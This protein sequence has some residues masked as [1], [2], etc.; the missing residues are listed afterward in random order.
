MA[1]EKYPS[2]RIAN[3]TTVTTTTTTTDY[4]YP[5]PRTPTHTPSAR[6]P[7]SQSHYRRGHGHGTNGSI[8]SNGSGSSAG[9]TIS[10]NGMTTSNAV[11]ACY[12]PVYTVSGHESWISRR[13][14]DYLKQLANKAG[15]DPSQQ[16][17]SDCRIARSGDGN[18]TCIKIKALPRSYKL[19]ELVGEG[20]A[21][22][23]FELKLPDG[24]YF[25]HED[26]LLMRV[27][28]APVRPDFP[29]FDHVEQQWHYHTRIKPILGHY[30]LHS[31]LAVIRGSGIVDA[32]NDYLRRHDQ[33]RKQKFRGTFVD[34][35]DW[36]F[37][38][39]DMR[40]EDDEALLVE[41][42]PKWL[43]QSP[44]APSSAIR[45]RQCAKELRD[46]VSDPD[47]RKPVPTK[48]KP[49]PLTLGRDEYN[50]VRIESAYRLL[51]ELDEPSSTSVDEGSGTS[52]NDI[53]QQQKQHRL[54]AT[55]G[56]LRDEPALKILREAQERYDKVGPLR[57]DESDADFSLAMTLRDCT[58]LAQI[59]MVPTP[60]SSNYTSTASNDHHHGATSAPA[61]EPIPPLKT[62]FVDFDMKSSKHRMSNW[63]NTER[64]LIE[65]GFYTAHRI[66]CRGVIYRPPTMC[67]LELQEQQQERGGTSREQGSTPVQE[68]LICI[69][70]KDEGDDAE[71]SQPYKAGDGWSKVYTVRTDAAKLQ[72]CLEGQLAKPFGP[73]GQ[74]S[75]GR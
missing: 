67:V 51:P 11:A 30:V 13:D 36:A 28:K 5:N 68:E 55:L 69:I 29:K 43:S 61:R 22:A 15:A 25:R 31:E 64:T 1:W 32:M 34:Q 21:N 3:T 66:S 53:S 45:C 26:G 23:V 16:H 35:S 41:F 14:M 63:R 39:E 38:L 27:A 57:A 44:S 73:S 71:A 70:D 74:Q 24:E 49:C 2:S 56:L 40:P 10:G 60:S 9:S 33:S 8:N 58:C 48:A 52:S 72:E 18:N 7:T 37:L 46:Y 65:H 59:Q 42:K 20:A 50:L 12:F 19:G 17:H 54:N 47:P 75:R 4:D 6:L 62:R